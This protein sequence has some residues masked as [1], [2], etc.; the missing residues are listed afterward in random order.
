MVDRCAS[1]EMGSVSACGTTTVDTRN[2]QFCFVWVVP[3]QMEDAMSRGLVIVAGALA[4]LSGS[5]LPFDRAEAGA[6]A[7]APSKYAQAGHATSAHV[8]AVHQT[9]VNRQARNGD[10][11]ITEYS[12]SSAKTSSVPGR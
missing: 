1:R 8:A 9:S 3:N 12:S 5:M 10:S 7:S 4:I 11:A 2:V 6:S